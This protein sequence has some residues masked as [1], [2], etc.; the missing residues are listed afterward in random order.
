ML[1]ARSPSSLRTGTTM[2]TWRT[3]MAA[4]MGD[5]VPWRLKPGYVRA[6]SK[7]LAEPAGHRA[8]LA[9]VR[10]DHV[11]LADEDRAGERPGQ[12]HLPGRQELA[13]GAELV[14]QPGDAVGGMAEYPGRH[15]GLL[16]RLVQVEHG[17]DP[18]QVAGVRADGT[19]AG[20]E[21]GVGGVVRDRVDDGAQVA[22]LRVAHLHPRVQDLQRRGDPPGRVED[23]QRG[24]PRAPQRP[25]QDER[26]LYL[27]PRA[28]EPA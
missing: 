6:M 4:R 26:Q 3:V 16:D 2:S 18:A 5:H 25:V 9:E 19:A 24:H 14:G 8:E 20:D 10:V 28:D 27:V 1:G 21:A 22:G 7:A 11:A 15:A 17:R 23:V 13:V 12:D